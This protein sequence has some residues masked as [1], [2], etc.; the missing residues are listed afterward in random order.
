[1]PW[2]VSFNLALDTVVP[3]TGEHRITAGQCL[4]AEPVRAIYESADCVVLLDGAVQAAATEGSLGV[5]VLEPE[6]GR[7]GRAVIHGA[8]VI[9]AAGGPSAQAAM[10]QVVARVQCLAL[11]RGLPDSDGG[12]PETLQVLRSIAAEPLGERKVDGHQAVGFRATR[13]SIR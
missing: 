7:P 5:T 3:G 4:I 9:T 12:F 6:P 8:S 2:T 1:M 13:G 10:A 11:M